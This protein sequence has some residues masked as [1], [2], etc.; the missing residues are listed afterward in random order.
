MYINTT[1]K[2]VENVHLPIIPQLQLAVNVVDYTFTTS[3]GPYRPPYT[4]AKA[5][6]SQGA[7]RAKGHFKVNLS[8]TGLTLSSTVS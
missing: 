6:Y 7:D 5:C 2:I 1:H 3:I 4:F 8:G